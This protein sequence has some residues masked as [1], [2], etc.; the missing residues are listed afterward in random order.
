VTFLGGDLERKPPAELRPVVE[1][2]NL[3][4]VD[5]VRNE[6]PPRPGVVV[7]SGVLNEPQACG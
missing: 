4:Y 1:A 7:A 2:V 6:M 3:E 5:G